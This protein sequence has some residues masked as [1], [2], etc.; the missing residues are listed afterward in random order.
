VIIARASSLCDA[1]LSNLQYAGTLVTA[2]VYTTDYTTF[3]SAGFDDSPCVLNLKKESKVATRFSCF[4]LGRKK[5]AALTFNFDALAFASY[6][7][8]ALRYAV[9]TPSLGQV[10][11]WRAKLVGELSFFFYFNV[12]SQAKHCHR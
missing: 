11:R 10:S 5:S 2:G 9:V 6:A 1:S 4:F 8:L 12:L 3:F 7:S